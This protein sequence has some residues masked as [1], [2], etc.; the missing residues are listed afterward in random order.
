MGFQQLPNLLAFVSMQ[1]IVAKLRIRIHTVVAHA[2]Q[3]SLKRL[4]SNSFL[5]IPRPLRTAGGPVMLCG[6]G[7]VCHRKTIDLETQICVKCGRALG[8]AEERLHSL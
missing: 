7:G 5:K 6:R 2:V 3:E 8:L 4:L 1:S